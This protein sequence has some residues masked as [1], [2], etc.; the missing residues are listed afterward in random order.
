M[1]PGPKP[2][3]DSLTDAPVV[4]VKVPRKALREFDAAAKR[5]GLQ[6]AE[7]IRLA[8]REFVDSANAGGIARTR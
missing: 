3:A 1:R 6:R 4:A 8:M 2:K 7:A 5:R